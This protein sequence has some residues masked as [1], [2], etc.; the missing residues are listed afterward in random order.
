[1]PTPTS[2]R[3]YS[4]GDYIP[5]HG[6]VQETTATAYVV[7]IHGGTGRHYVPFYGPRGVD[8]VEPATPLVTLGG[9]S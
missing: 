6:W 3:R 1:M 8:P 9:A 5:G 7:Q 2:P 4:I